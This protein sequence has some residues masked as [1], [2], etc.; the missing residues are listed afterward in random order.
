MSLA[1]VVTSLVVVATPG[2]GTV[3]TVDAGLG[4]GHR[5]ALLAAVACTL[6]IVPHL[7]ASAMGL[8]AL[9]AA[10]PIAYAALTWAGVVV[11]LVFAVMTWRGAG[12]GLPA[13]RARQEVVAV[14]ARRVLRDGVVLNL[15]NPKLTLFFV[16]FLP[17]F[18]PTGA[19]VAGMAALGAVFM[20]LTLVVFAGY[21][22]GAA[23]LRPVLLGR[24]HLLGV[25]GKGFA[26]AYLA[27]AVAL[28]VRLMVG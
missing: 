9:L 23:S 14:R 13:D 6:G 24:P 16:A 21:G 22:L 5:G 27:V 17:Q 10:S 7:L 25:A 12:H 8:A 2:T 15:F 28:A 3:Y 1:F 4:R 19:G 18:A 26:V 11:L 20:L